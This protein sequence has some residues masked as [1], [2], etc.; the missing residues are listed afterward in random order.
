MCQRAS[1]RAHKSHPAAGAPARRTREVS[2]CAN[3]AAATADCRAPLRPQQLAMALDE[4]GELE[5]PTDP[6]EATH[7]IRQGWQ[8]HQHHPL[9]HT[10]QQEQEQEQ[11]REQQ[12]QGQQEQQ[13]EE[14]IVRAHPP[15]P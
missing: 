3:V 13:Q 12:E 2:N 1:G 5:Q 11:E 6:K 9:H 10:Q 8:Q 4:A 14:A 7:Q 15:L